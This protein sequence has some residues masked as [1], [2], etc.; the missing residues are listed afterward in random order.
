VVSGE[1]IRVMGMA[2]FNQKRI[3]PFS[4]NSLFDQNRTLPFLADSLFD[5]I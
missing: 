3:L 4:A 2:V 1:H 5:Q